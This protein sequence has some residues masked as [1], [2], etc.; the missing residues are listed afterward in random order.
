MASITRRISKTGKEFWQVQI[1][2]IGFK[3]ISEAFD[4]WKQ[5]NDFAI[6][7]EA[8]L[9]NNELINRDAKKITIKDLID[10][11][12]KAHPDVPAKWK[13]RL[14][15]LQH[16]N[17]LGAFSVKTLVPSVLDKWIKARLEFNKP[18][19]VYWYYCNLKKAMMWHSLRN[20][21]R[22]DLFQIAKC[23][24]TVTARNRRISDAEINKLQNAM[25]R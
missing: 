11:F 1:R 19:T 20:D 17:E 10:E 24:T 5:A 23:P 12:L 7:T 9:L 22:Q 2:R 21:Y 14:K 8:K 18:P 25:D 16:E 15:Y 3:H 6:K 13:T 4:T